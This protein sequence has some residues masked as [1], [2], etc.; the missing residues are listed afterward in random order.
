MK[1]TLHIHIGAHRTATTSTQSFLRKNFVAL[2]GKGYFHP[3][4]AGRHFM[5]MNRLFAGRETVAE[6]VADIDA[7]AD[8][9]PHDIH[10]IVLSDEDICMREDLSV[11][12]QFRDHY[13]VRIVFSMRRQDLWLESWHQQNVKWQWNPELAHLTFPDFLKRRDEFF[14]IDYARITA[15]LKAL[16][17]AEALSLL[18]FEKGQMPDGPVD[19]FCDAIGLLDRDGLVPPAHSNTSLSPLMSE[20]MRT[21]PLDEF[22]GP[23]RRVF[24]QAC[25]EV[26]AAQRH[27]GTDRSALL[28]GLAD[29]KAILAD[30]ADSNA[31]VA[32]EFF[33]RD[34]LFLEPLPPENAVL[35]DQTLTGDAYQ[36]IETFVAPMLRALVAR[37]LDEAEEKGRAK[38]AKD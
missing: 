8:S 14:W 1:R 32:R 38:S 21:L 26:D 25:A 23:E 4:A 18:V 20:F 3:Y 11:L 5:L 35:A 34:S 16:F 6:A 13:D 24:E 27:A 31:A 9:K 36:T 2:Q 15:H 28:M 33:D 7:R 22:P 37:R 10:H 17:G 29:R 30:Y 19:A 12:A